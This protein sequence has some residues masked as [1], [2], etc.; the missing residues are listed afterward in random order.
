[1]A[2]AVL[3]DAASDPHSRPAGKKPTSDKH[4]NLKGPEVPLTS[5]MRSAEADNVKANGFHC[6]YF[7]DRRVPGAGLSPQLASWGAAPRG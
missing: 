6:V 5:S 2:P 1:M 7:F 3:K 4:C